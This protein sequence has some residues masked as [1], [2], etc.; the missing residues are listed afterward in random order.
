[1]WPLMW[2]QY[3]FK[4]EVVSFFDNYFAEDVDIHFVNEH[5]LCNSWKNMGDLYKLSH[6]FIS[7]EF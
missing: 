2:T 7:P 5:F 1:M 6:S 3:I 4:N